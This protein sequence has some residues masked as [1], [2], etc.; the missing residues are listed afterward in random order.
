MSES[1]IPFFE[2]SPFDVSNWDSLL[3][4]WDSS[5]HPVSPFAEIA[6]VA[7]QVERLRRQLGMVG[8]VIP[9]KDIFEV[10]LDV[11]GYKPEDLKISV[12]N[13][14]LTVSGTH[15]EKNEDES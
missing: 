8:G 13:N 7:G 11:Q 6:R 4:A 5:R 2:E 14:I 9:R 10:D 3:R 15:D 12:Q 1:L